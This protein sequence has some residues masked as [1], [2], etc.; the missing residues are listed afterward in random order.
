MLALV[1]GL[2]TGLSLIIAIGA[3]N[4]FVIRQG[5][6]KQYVFLVVG[7]CSASDALL[8]VLGIGGLG[9]LLQRHPTILDFIKWFGVLYLTWFG[10]R[11]LLAVFK[12]QALV[13]ANEAKT[14]FKQVIGRTLGFTF[15]N[16]HVYL[17]TVIFLGGI[18]SQFKTHKWDFAAGAVISSILWF[19]SIGFG[20]KAASKFMSRPIFWKILDGFIALVM[21]TL[22]LLLAFYKLK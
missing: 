7:V 14:S 10:V 5:L 8:I 1:T 20:A 22:A 21:F 3:Q 15:L 12:D 6:N 2:F 11:S 18:G 17:D 16:P 4:A 9:Q 19:T 13:A